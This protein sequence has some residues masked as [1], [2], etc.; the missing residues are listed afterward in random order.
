MKLYWK[1]SS[2]IV[3]TL[4]WWGLLIPHLISARDDIFFGIGALCVLVYPVIT[5][6]W[7]KTEFKSLQMK[8][9][10]WK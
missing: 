1:I 2:F 10:N 4:A 5:H 6:M 3:V 9:E 8:V 7:F